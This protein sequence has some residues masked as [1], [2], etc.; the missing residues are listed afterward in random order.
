MHKE[1]YDRVV[2]TINNHQQN[3]LEGIPAT[4]TAMITEDE[5]QKDPITQAQTLIKLV[6]ATAE[7]AGPVKEKLIAALHTWIRGEMQ[8]YGHAVATLT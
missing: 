2:T 5:F 1:D 3:N 4:L 7:F 8:I 6:N